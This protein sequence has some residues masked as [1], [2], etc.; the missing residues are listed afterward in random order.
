V[1]V[2]P[3]ILHATPGDSRSGHYG[4]LAMEVVKKHPKADLDAFR[5]IY[6]LVTTYDAAFQ[7]LNRRLAK[8]SVT[9]AGFNV[10]MV[11]SHGDFRRSGCAMHR[12]GELLLVSRANVTG[13][14]DNLE[15]KGL[16]SRTGDIL[17]RRSKLVRV[18]PEGERRLHQI[19]PGHLGAV[20]RLIAGLKLEE[21]NQLCDLLHKI[22][23]PV[24]QARAEETEG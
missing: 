12:L 5:A 11:L 10:L 9:L 1:A 16:V 13:L 17:D 14:I 18:T 6:S 21:I 3:N 24:E 20:R 23:L 22:R 19:L 7:H 4:S 8:H 2:A 15:R